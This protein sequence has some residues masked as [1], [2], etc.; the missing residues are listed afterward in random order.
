MPET[1]RRAQP[2]DKQKGTISPSEER[3]TDRKADKM[4]D[5]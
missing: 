2:I 5:K 3:K 1:P 4:L